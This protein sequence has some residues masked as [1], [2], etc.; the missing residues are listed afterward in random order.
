MQVTLGFQQLDKIT[1]DDSGLSAGSRLLQEPLGR[2]ISA[3]RSKTLDFFSGSF[4]AEVR[5]RR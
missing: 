2:T 5:G 4:S 1:A 3:A